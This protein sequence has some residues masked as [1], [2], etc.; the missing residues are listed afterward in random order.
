MIA[1]A[2]GVAAEQELSE[3][4]AAPTPL[5][6]GRHTITASD[7][8][9]SRYFQVERSINRSSMWVGVT[10]ETAAGEE[11]VGMGGDVKGNDAKTECGEGFWASREFTAGNQIG[12]AAYHNSRGSC[13]NED[14]LDG[15]VY[16]SGDAVGSTHV[17]VWEEPP[18]ENR[19]ILPPP[20]TEVPWSGERQDKAG[21]LELGESFATAKAVDNGEYTA[22]FSGTDLGFTTVDLDWGEHLEVSMELIDGD[23]DAGTN[24]VYLA[25]TLWSPLG[26]EVEWADTDS[27]AFGSESLRIDGDT[28]QTTEAASPAI[29][30]RNR[31]APLNSPAAFPGTYYL[32]FGYWSGAEDLPTT[33]DAEVTVN[34]RIVK[35]DTVD[36]PYTQDAKPV[37][38]IGGQEPVSAEGT[39]E[40]AGSGDSASGGSSG[41]STPW[42]GVIALF[43]GSVVMTAAGVVLLGRHRRFLA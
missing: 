10:N 34:V 29:Q 13:L 33:I 19:S 22:A 35:D 39:D 15:S 37:P 11:A 18:V 27:E 12:S 30:W 31:E 7:A 25:P 17:V 6:V 36:S 23:A 32:T 4:E 21:S 2:T 14:K 9:E 20:S 1:P 24:T 3:D 8:Y 28:S 26:G 16:L 43:G 38:T 42:G 5:A 41:S 40:G